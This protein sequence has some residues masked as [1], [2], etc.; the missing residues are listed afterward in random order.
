MQSTA[1]TVDE[2]LATVPPERL[3]ALNKLRQLCRDK[4]PGYEE[5]MQY[6]MPSY[7]KDGT[8]EISFNSQKNYISFY[9]LKKDVMDRYREQLQDCGKG[10]IRYRKPDQID[11]D[12]VEKLLE[13][14]AESSAE[15]CP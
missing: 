7:S 9:V 1:T 13:G 10:C 2:Y 6:G 12:V 3:A 5:S 15:I 8:V 11:F 14:T 4:L